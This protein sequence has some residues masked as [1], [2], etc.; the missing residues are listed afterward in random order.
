MKTIENHELKDE[1]LALFCI[2][3]QDLVIRR[4]ILRVTQ[5]QM[6]YKC[7]VSLKTIQN[8]ENYRCTDA[9]LIFAYKRILEKTE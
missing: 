4:N 8:F 3:V 2:K 9:Y 6:A 1:Y 7:K 5:S